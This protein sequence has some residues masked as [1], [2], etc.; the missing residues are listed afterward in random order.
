MVSIWVKRRGDE[1]KVP[2]M[3]QC[4]ERSRALRQ[5]GDPRAMIRFVANL[6]SYNSIGLVDGFAGD[7][8]GTS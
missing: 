8:K 4:S 5:L 3:Y 1:L 2:S 7:N 6:L